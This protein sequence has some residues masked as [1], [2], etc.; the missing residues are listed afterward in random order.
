MVKVYKLNMKGG[1][2]NVIFLQFPIDFLI[3]PKLIINY[4]NKIQFKSSLNM[5]KYEKCITNK[6]K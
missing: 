3:I 4:S 1:I 2:I 6:K 5:F